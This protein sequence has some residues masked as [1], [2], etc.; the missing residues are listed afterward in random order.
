MGA[1]VW[2]LAHFLQS[3]LLKPFRERVLYSLFLI[4]LLWRL[5][6]LPAINTFNQERFNQS[7]KAI[8]YVRENIPKGNMILADEIGILG[9]FLPEYTFLDPTGLIHKDMPKEG[10]YRYEFL[11]VKYRPMVIIN[12]HYMKRDDMPENLKEP[13]RFKSEGQ[14]IDQYDVMYLVPGKSV[15]LRILKR[16]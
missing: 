2:G 4:I 11:A 6:Q 9:Y 5:F 13:I 12:S 16:T 10:Y 7:I 8:D 3:H 15:T 1:G 14:S